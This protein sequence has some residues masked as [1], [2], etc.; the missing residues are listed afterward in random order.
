MD[1]NLSENMESLADLL[2][3]GLS[4]HAVDEIAKLV[5]TVIRERVDT[6]VDG[7]ITK[8]NSFL[9]MKVDEIKEYALKEL[10][11][12]EE[13]VQNGHL[14]ESMKSMMAINID[15]ADKGSAISDLVNV[16]EESQEN[17]SILTKEVEKLMEDNEKLV[18]VAHALQGKIKL[19]EK[20]K[21]ELKEEA[22][23]LVES[24][25]LPFE[26][27]EK[28]VMVSNSEEGSIAPDNEEI[29]N[30]NEFL[31]PE[32]MRFMPITE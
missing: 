32:V 25:Q 12:D 8:V 2:P 27:S 4:E 28:A 9:R 21:F 24:Q 15:E 20:Q 5:D 19:L 16:N 29:Q 10:Q 14:F 1:N 23:N 13:F 17:V 30:I 22:E 18:S 11:Q 26:S 6:E 31:T 3:E 7:L